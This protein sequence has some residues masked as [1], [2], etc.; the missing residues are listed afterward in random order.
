MTPIA[1]TPL[2]HRNAYTR[3]SYAQWV[4]RALGLARSGD[5]APISLFESS[6]PEPRALLRQTVADLVEPA[7]SNA[8]VSAFNGGNPI[9]LDLL[10]ER[11]GVTRLRVLATTGAT[12][13]LSL[14]YRT[15]A[16]P[17]DRVL[18]ETPGFDLFHDLAADHGLIVDTF[19]RDGPGF[20][21]DVATVEAALRPDTRMI[22]VSNLHNPSG[23]V[24]APAV[25][26]ELVRLAERRDVLL[27]AD[28]VYADY[29]APS[30]WTPVASLSPFAISISSLTKIFGLATLRCGWIVGG[31][32][33]VAAVRDHAARIEFGISNLAHAVAA[34]VLRN[35][36]PFRAHTDATLAAARPVLEH[37]A[38]AMTAEGLI[39]GALPDAGCIYFPRLVGIADTEAFTNRLIRHRRI[40]VA[41]GEYFGA[42]GH[43]RIG[44]GMEADK[45]ARALTALGEEL[46]HTA[47][48]PTRTNQI[49]SNA[50]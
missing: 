19:R 48:S 30:D 14:L 44:F 45:L 20:D 4:R 28:E 32:E 35:P 12:G 50:R 46:R 33:V 23:M 7:L 16:R 9:V 42:P 41:P 6:V 37:W 2:A 39:E 18:V 8:Y 22:I 17:G 1:Q 31:A 3:Q 34:S 24:I 36:A 38:A 13:G 11:Y 10:A 29:A 40:I 5:D 49:A 26:A 27:V 25:L 21:I 47:I 43:V 15:F